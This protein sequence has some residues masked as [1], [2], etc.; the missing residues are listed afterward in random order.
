MQISLQS[1]SDYKIQEFDI[2]QVLFNPSS[3]FYPFDWCN[4]WSQGEY[5]KWKNYI[6]VYQCS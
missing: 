1:L 3:V 6:T 5:V 4:S 2:I